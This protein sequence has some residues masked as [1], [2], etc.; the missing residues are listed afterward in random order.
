MVQESGR[1]QVPMDVYSWTR[2]Q[3]LVSLS[4][5][6]I[7]SFAAILGCVLF[8]IPS[9]VRAADPVTVNTIVSRSGAQWNAPP[10]AQPFF[11]TYTPPSSP[12]PSRQ[13]PSEPDPAR[14]P[15]VPRFP[16]SIID[17]DGRTRVRDTSAFPYR[18]LVFIQLDYDIFYLECTGILIGPHTV[19]TAG[20]CVHDPSLGWAKHARIFPGVDG[21]NAPFGAADAVE[22]YS[23]TGWLESNA[24]EFDY[25]AIALDHDIGSQTGWLGMSV[26]DNTTL[27]HLNTRITGYPA[28]KAHETMWTMTGPLK[29]VAPLRLFYPIDTYAGESGAPIYNAFPSRNCM[30]C[31]VGIH[32]YGIDSDPRE[33]YNSGV[34]ITSAVLDNFISWRNLP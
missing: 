4:G 33:K 19:A 34:R 26:L 21:S 9:P 10:S 29:R 11:P 12:K 22:F 6:L 13:T 3:R 8:F 17:L 16:G 28:D 31:V 1:G 2:Q 23:V 30:Y 14:R 18:A 15:L 7:F 32:G 20:H 24:P 5:R 25:G 27:S